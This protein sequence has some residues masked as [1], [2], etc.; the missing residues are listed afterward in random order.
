MSSIPIPIFALQ[1]IASSAGIC[2]ISSICLCTAGI[3]A[4]G[5]SIL[6][7]IG[8]DR[9]ALFVREMHVGHGLGFHPL[10]RIDDQERSFAGRERTGNFV[11]K[12]DM[13]RRVREIEAI[14]LP[15]LRGVAH[16][17]RMRLDRDPAFAFQIHR[18]EQLILPFAVLD[19][20]RPLEQTI[21]E[22]RLAVIDMRDDAEVARELDGHEGLHYAGAPLAGQWNG[23]RPVGADREQFC[24]NPIGRFLPQRAAAV[25]R[26]RCRSLSCHRPAPRRSRTN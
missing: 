21:G 20:A 17:H 24:P 14:F 12:I 9:Q 1:S 19:R 2:R 22:R 25:I 16:R 4:F 13:P 6:L 10:R 11:G 15:V 23:P 18:I 3:S 8:H 5:R 7:M 26:T